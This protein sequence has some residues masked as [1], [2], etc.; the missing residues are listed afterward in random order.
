M[1]SQSM[2]RGVRK[3]TP[4]LG[5]KR[6]WV[7]SRVDRQDAASECGK[8]WVELAAGVGGGLHRRP[9]YHRLV[10]G[11]H[12]SLVIT[13]LDALE[14]VASS[15]DKVSEPR[16]QSLPWRGRLTRGLLR[17][18]CNLNQPTNYLGS[19]AANARVFQLIRTARGNAPAPG[20]STLEL[21]RRRLEALGHA[22]TA[23][24]WLLGCRPQLAA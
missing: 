7:R 24:R 10:L 17:P 12:W 22:H 2:V 5:R 18:A 23:E 1:S 21:R 6:C 13:R 11:G 19:L 8:V 16:K 3:D 4:G 9:Q 15:E 14:Y 20:W